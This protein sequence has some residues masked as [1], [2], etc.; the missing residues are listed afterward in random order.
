MNEQCT[1]QYMQ[2]LQDDFHG[3]LPRQPDRQAEAA[4]VVRVPET[5]DGAWYRARCVSAGAAALLDASKLSSWAAAPDCRAAAPRYGALPGVQ[6]PAGAPAR[7]GETASCAALPPARGLRGRMLRRATGRC[8]RYSCLL[9]A[10][11]AQ[12]RQPAGA[13]AAGADCRP[14]PPRYGALPEYSCL[15][16]AP[17]AQIGDNFMCTVVS[18]SGGTL[19]VALVNIATNAP[20]GS[21]TVQRWLPTVDYPA[22]PATAAAAPAAPAATATASPSIPEVP[23]P[24]L[25]DKSR[26]ILVDA[27]EPS[28]LFVR[29]SDVEQQREFDDIVME[30]AVY[31]MTA[32]PLT[33]PPVV[34]QT[35]VAKY[36]DDMCYRA[37]C[38]RVN[39]KLNK[40]LLEYIEYGN[41]TVAYLEGIYACPPELT[42]S[43]RPTLVSQATLQMSQKSFNDAAMQFLDGLKNE[44]TELIL[45]TASGAASAASGSAV[46]L[47]VAQ[48]ALDVNRT[49]S[50]LCTPEW[51]KLLER[52]GDVMDVRAPMYEELD[53]VDLPSGS[54]ELVVLDTNMLRG[55]SIAG[56]ERGAPHAAKALAL[57]E[58]LAEYCN[59]ALCKDPYLPKLEELCVAH[60]PKRNLW[61]RATLVQQE[62]GAGSAAAELL[63]L[64]YGELALLP[65]ARLRKM[66][67]EFVTG[68]PAAC[69][70]VEIKDF[71]KEPTDAQVALAKQHMKVDDRGVGTLRV[72]RALKQQAPGDFLVEAPELIRAMT[73]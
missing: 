61:V 72:A 36:T 60:C 6:L 8:P 19:N 3:G 53:Y 70:S 34:G 71:P 49:V 45:S 66:M 35:V 4:G 57:S 47:S 59:S 42:L 16:G 56:H 2:L 13:L 22:E 33:E 7:A 5:L 28:R 27:T 54:F 30:I 48:S 58:A 12:V 20:Q 62:S 23:R 64:D 9:G 50:A 63:L 17:A 11:A 44:T 14:L 15:L 40:Y 21:G 32:K 52:G 55:G 51:V 29:S 43:S 26:V 69:C 65:V 38:R 10:P 41:T 31:G 46:R 67:P 68:L 1:D 39:S 18:K 25:T 73:V 37:L 24:P